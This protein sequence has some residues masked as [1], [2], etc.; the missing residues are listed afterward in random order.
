MSYTLSDLIRF[1]QRLDKIAKISLLSSAFFIG[2]LLLSPLLPSREIPDTVTNMS[3]IGAD[4]N[5]R[6]FL[7]ITEY[8]YV[9]IDEPTYDDL[10]AHKNESIFLGVSYLTS[11]VKYS[12]ALSL[13]DASG[14]SSV[15]V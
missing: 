6:Y 2:W 11:N 15:S 14:K 4:K 1:Y 7:L 9:Y 5:Q 3:P 8:L 13:L 10:S 12:T